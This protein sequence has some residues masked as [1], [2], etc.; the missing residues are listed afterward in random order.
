MILSSLCVF[1]AIFGISS[2]SGYFEIQ[3]TQIRNDRGEA[4]DGQCCD[5]ERDS[6]NTCTEEC[7]TFFRVCL[8]EYQSRVTI[9][10]FCTFGNVTSPVYGGNSFSK[11][12]DSTSTR[13]KLPFEFAW[14]V[15]NK[16]IALWNLEM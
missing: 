3:I 13:L 4:L 16:V 2:G 10:G 9:G 1:L 6:D 15:S 11:P 8:K 14:T 5:G 12:L 7:D